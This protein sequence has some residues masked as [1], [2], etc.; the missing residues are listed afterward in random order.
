MSR[1][2]IKKLPLNLSTMYQKIDNPMG[3]RPELGEFE[4]EAES[5]EDA[6]LLAQPRV[7]ANEPNMICPFSEKVNGFIAATGKTRES[8]YVHP[9]VLYRYNGK[10]FN[11]SMGK[12]HRDQPASGNFMSKDD[13]KADY[14]A[15]KLLA[16]KKIEAALAHLK[17]MN[18]LGVSIDYCIDGD[19]HGIYEQYMYLEVTEGAYS[20]RVEYSVQLAFTKPR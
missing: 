3:V 9:I 4:I 8:M 14:L 6:R 13:A 11:E 16:D 2:A 5:I 7:S 1:F 15:H 17:S 10:S 20:F 18:E 12:C 19:T